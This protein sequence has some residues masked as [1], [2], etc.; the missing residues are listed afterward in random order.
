MKT[1]FGFCFFVSALTCLLPRIDN[2]DT[3]LRLVLEEVV[4]LDHTSSWVPVPENHCFWE[5]QHTGSYGP[6]MVLL[7]TGHLCRTTHPSQRG[8][9]MAALSWWSDLSGDSEYEQDYMACKWP[10]VT[11]ERAITGH[12]HADVWG[13]TS[14]LLVLLIANN[15]PHELK[16]SSMLQKAKWI[17]IKK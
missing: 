5:A 2:L 4:V 10:L 3:L 15:S 16:Y 13:C 7:H 11:W 12:G 8:S 14:I 9:G 1:L 17:I 6:Q